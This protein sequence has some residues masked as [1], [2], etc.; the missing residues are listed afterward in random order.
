LGRRLLKK[1]NETKYNRI[2]WN[3]K[4]FNLGRID[5]LIGILRVQLQA[6]VYRYEK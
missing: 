2:S 3:K 4:M 1:K 6:S 5:L